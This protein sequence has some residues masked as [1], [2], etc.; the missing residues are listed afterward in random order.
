MKLEVIDN[1]IKIIDK[2][3]NYKKEVK[4]IYKCLPQSIENPEFT[5]SMIAKKEIY[6]IKY[7]NDT[8]VAKELFKNSTNIIIENKKFYCSADL[9]TFNGIDCFMENVK[10][11]EC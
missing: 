9:K 8:R 5:A 1:K 7:I 4:S 3:F 11:I 6:N 10:L 2:K